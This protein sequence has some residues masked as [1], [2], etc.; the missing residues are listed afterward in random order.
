MQ[1]TQRKLFGAYYTPDDVVQSLVGWA[2][3]RPSDRMIDPSCG[4]G[5]FLVAHENSV[6]VEG[7]PKAAEIVHARAPGSLIHQGDFFSW[8]A[9]TTERFD[10]AAGN[11]PF[12]RYQRFT[13]AVRQA[14]QR[15]CARHGANFT[16]LSSSWA[17]FLV[18]TAALLKPGGRMAFVVPAE[19]GHAPYALPLLKYL[20]KHFAEVTILAVE[21]KLFPDLS[22][23]CWLLHCS[24]FGSS[25]RSIG[26]NAVRRF[27]PSKRPPAPERVISLDEWE[28]W[29]FR[30][31]P[32]L[33]PRRAMDLYRSIA[34]S[35][36]A[37]RLS[38]FAQVSIGYVTGAN[39]FFHMRPALP[40]SSES[41]LDSLSQ[42]CEMGATSAARQS[43]RAPS[44]AGGLRTSRTS[45]CACVAT[46]C[47][48]APSDR[49]STRASAARHARA[50]SAGTARPGTPFPTCVFRT[51]SSR[52]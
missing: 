26:F 21:E 35:P 37:R 9:N 36:Q 1:V 3:A 7:D 11:P 40:S 18:A 28:Q 52:T 24:G 27:E 10:C 33:L 25:A 19:I 41:P 45:C 43:A 5:R 34:N 15:L 8:A 4:D 51:R 32:F 30:L 12:I 2:V 44:S 42:R 50:T 31:R 22:E 14:S 38:S 47:C 20:V 39:E 48:P 16:S 17:P 29:G 6:G 46:T 13:G 23:D 49:I